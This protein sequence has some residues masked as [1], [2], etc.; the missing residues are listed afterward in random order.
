[1]Q[2]QGPSQ[3][4]L[5]VG[6]QLRHIIAETLQ[7]GHFRDEI[8]IDLASAVT[9]TEVRTSP[10]LKQATAYVISLGGEDMDKI[11]PALNHNAP[12]FQK[13]INAKANLKFTPKIRFKHDSSFENVQKLDALLSNIKYSD[14]E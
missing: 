14:Q 5:R 7:R 9:V 8:L 13:D 2:Q 12:A 4:Q 6:E 3:R 11:L 1:M 10:D